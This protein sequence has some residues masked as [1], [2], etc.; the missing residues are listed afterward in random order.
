MVRA[1]GEPKRRATYEDLM[2]V[3]DTATTSS[4]R[5][6]PDGDVPLTRW[7]PPLAGDGRTA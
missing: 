5:I 4:C 3:P 7:W 6:G 2:Q 1:M